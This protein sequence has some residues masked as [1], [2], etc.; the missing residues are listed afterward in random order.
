LVCSAGA[1]SGAVI[2]SGAEACWPQ[3]SRPIVE[4]IVLSVQFRVM[5]KLMAEVGCEEAVSIQCASCTFRH[6][7]GLRGINSQPIVM[8]QAVLSI[9]T[10]AENQTISISLVLEE[11]ERNEE[12]MYRGI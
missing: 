10:R 5:V 11:R 9:E 1:A 2:I 6:V 4:V 12:N 8:C 3:Q 7:N